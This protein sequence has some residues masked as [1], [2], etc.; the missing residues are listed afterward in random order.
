MNW[1]VRD[2]IAAWE[3]QRSCYVHVAK[4]RVRKISGK[5]WVGYGVCIGTFSVLLFCVPHCVLFINVFASLYSFACSFV[6]LSIHSYF[7][8]FA[9]ITSFLSLTLQFTLYTFHIS[10][11][12]TIFSIVPFIVVNFSHSLHFVALSGFAAVCWAAVSRLLERFWN[13]TQQLLEIL[14]NF[15]KATR[16]A[17]EQ[18]K[19]VQMHHHRMR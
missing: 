15:C 9:H 8:S 17:N 11:F 16:L 3:Q 13:K 7:Q 18:L 10:N 19:L 6:C 12:W 5:A 4:I 2:R 14:W 1:C